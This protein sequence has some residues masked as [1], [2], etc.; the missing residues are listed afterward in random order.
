MKNIWA[1]PVRPI[2]ANTRLTPLAPELSENI[3]IALESV[4]AARTRQTVT[5]TGRVIRKTIRSRQ[6]TLAPLV[7]AEISQRHPDLS[8][9][10]IQ[11]D[12]VELPDQL[13]AERRGGVQE[14][15]AWLSHNMTRQ[16]EGD[17]ALAASPPANLGS[18]RVRTAWRS[19]V[20]LS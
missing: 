7:L 10:V 1:S 12:P 6:P 16:R 13:K 3:R 11:G 20:A 15:R 5:L 19:S 9:R 14:M 18:S 17:T 8:V 2:R 4:E